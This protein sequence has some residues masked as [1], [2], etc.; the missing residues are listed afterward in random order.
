MNGC[1]ATVGWPVMTS[2]GIVTGPTTSENEVAFCP[3]TLLW[4][5]NRT[6]WPRSSWRRVISGAPPGGIATYRDPI[7]QA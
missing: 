3:A 1:P 4:A 2:G 5:K 7:S 6:V